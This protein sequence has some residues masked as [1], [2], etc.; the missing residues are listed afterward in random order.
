MELLVLWSAVFWQEIQLKEAAFLEVLWFLC[1]VAIPSIYSKNNCAD[2][3]MVSAVLERKI[4]L[5]NP[6]A[7]DGFLFS[8]L[9]SFDLSALLSTGSLQLLGRGRKHLVKHNMQKL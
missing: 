5:F 1:L 9:L 8:P 3:T 6:F 7:E 4:D 2:K